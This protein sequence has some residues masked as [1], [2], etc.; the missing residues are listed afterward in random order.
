MKLIK[1]KLDNGATDKD[2]ADEHFGSWVRYSKAFQQYRTLNLQDRNWKTIVHVLWGRTGTGKTRFC[3]DQTMN[4]PYWSPG[5]YQWY[6][7]YNGQKIVIFDDYRGEYPIQQLL[8]LL[9]RYPMNVPIKG[10]FVKWSPTKIYITSNLPPSD[11]Y[12]NSDGRTRA[13]LMRRLDNV[14]QIETPIY[15][16]IILFREYN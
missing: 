14:E 15:D 11:W 8:K 12:P 5:D 9:D 7:G 16:D 13:A 10:G 1:E 3:V 4:S 2:I 6:D